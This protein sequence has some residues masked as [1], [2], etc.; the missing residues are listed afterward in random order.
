MTYY[1]QDLKDLAISPREKLLTL[2]CCACMGIM[3]GLI[4]LASLYLIL[5]FLF[6]V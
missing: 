6:G 4:C 2:I 3:I 1:D 5:V